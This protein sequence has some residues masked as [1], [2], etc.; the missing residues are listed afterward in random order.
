MRKDC[1]MRFLFA[2]LALCCCGVAVADNAVVYT[3]TT[4]FYV[5]AQQHADDLA[6]RGAFGH[7][8]N[9]G[10]F[11]EGIGLGPTPDV[12]KRNC[13]YWGQRQLVEVAV[14]WSPIRRAYIAVARYR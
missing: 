2:L 9:H 5:P 14:S 8:R 13:C 4:S 10:V 3:T 7:C 1:T 12:A 6:R 11:F